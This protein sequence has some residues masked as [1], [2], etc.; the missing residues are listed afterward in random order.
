M[1]P[2]MSMQALP[3]GLCPEKFL[4]TLYVEPPEDMDQLRARMARLMSVE[5]NAN[6]RRRAM[7]APTSTTF[8]SIK[9]KRYGKFKNYTS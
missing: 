3:V 1:H 4:D 7:K 9:R 2:T 5:E 6:T 8:S